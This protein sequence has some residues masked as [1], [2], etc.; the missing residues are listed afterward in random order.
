MLDLSALRKNKITLEDYN[1]KQDIDNRL[2]MAQFTSMDLEVLEEILYSSISIPI[3]K[4]AKSLDLGDEELLPILQKLSKTGLFKFD[5]DAICVD[6]EIRKYFETQVLK[7]DSEFTPGM[8]FLQSLLRKVPI[9]VLPVWYAIPRTSN[10]IFD[11][12]VEKYLLTPQIFQRYLAELNFGDPVLT[13]IVNDVYN[14]VDFKVLGKD[15]IEKYN[16]TRPA[17]EELLLFLEFNFVCCLGYEKIED[18]WKEIVTPFQEWRDYLM[19]LK[20]TESSPIVTA[21]RIVKRRGG[22]FAFI[23]DL[24]ALLTMAKKTPIALAPDKSGRQLA[25]KAFVTSFAAKIEEKESDSPEFLNYFSKLLAKACLLKL[26]DI[27]DGRLYALEAANDWL[28]MRLEN[29]AMFLYRHPLNKL[30]SDLIPAQICTERNVREAE[31]SI[32]RALSSEWIYFDDFIHG[33]IVPLG[34]DSMIMLKR[35]GKIWKYALP[36][37]SEEELALIKATVLE[38]LFEFGVTSVGMHDGKECFYITPFG[39]SLFGR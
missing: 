8:E 33:V 5:G 25:T 29:R 2:L 23:H 24:A 1:Y 27:V 11:S 34:D 35:Q 31:K 30:I 6:K 39:Q 28:D 22:D 9:H 36:C 10:N 13:A 26:A 38:W 16:L 7:F 15:I 12:L 4:L 32:V 3:R 17:F 37:Y 18:E 14:A 19:F 20:E 21:D